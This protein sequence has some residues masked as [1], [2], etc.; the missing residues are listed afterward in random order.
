MAPGELVT[1]RL[2]AY[3]AAARELRL[4]AEQ[5]PGKRKNNR[6]ESSHVPSRRREPNL[7][8]FRSSGSAQRFLATHAG[9]ANTFTT[10]RHLISANTHRLLRSE[11]F[12]AWREAVEL[13]A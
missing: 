7:Q 3:G 9:V 13:A 5:I 11:A 2:R 8:A 1:G 12:A 4:G 10:R 6:A